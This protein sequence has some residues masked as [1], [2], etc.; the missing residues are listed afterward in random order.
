MANF[1]L[2]RYGPLRNWYVTWTEKGRSLRWSTR[3]TDQAQAKRRQKAFIADLLS[4]QPNGGDAKLGVVLR[5][6][7]DEKGAGGAS[8]KSCDHAVSS[9]LEFYGEDLKVSE[10]TPSQH[11]AYERHVRAKHGH[12]NSSINRRRT[13]LL[14]ALNHAKKNGVL[15]TVPHV[16]MLPLPPRRERYLTR[17]EAARLL[18][19]ARRRGLSHLVLFIR[20]GLY[21]GARATAILQLTWDRVDL[22]RGRIDFRRPEDTESKKRRPNAPINFKLLR[23]LRAERKTNKGRYVVTYNGRGIG[24]IRKSFM[25][26]A[27]AAGI[28]GI[29]PHTLKHTAL[30]WMLHNKLTPW[31]VSGLTATSVATI[32]RVYGHHVQDDLR[33]A[34]NSP[35]RR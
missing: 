33:E 25:D 8:Q 14:A 16:P 2:V 9:F 34:I 11:I 30:T 4:T 15:A 13:V 29:S 23:A 3:T 17:N 22:E 5:Q 21:T 26:V 32:L 27:N 28:K 20:I 31:Q 35:R 7:Q 24:L 10:L 1:K 19:E 12:K 6:Y 18:C